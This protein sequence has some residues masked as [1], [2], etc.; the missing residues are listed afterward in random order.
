MSGREFGPVFSWQMGPLKMITL[1]DYDVVK[2]LLLADNKVS[3][4]ARRMVT[5]R[6]CQH[7]ANCSYQP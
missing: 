6:L 5:I 3:G 1:L 2:G 4:A 7:F